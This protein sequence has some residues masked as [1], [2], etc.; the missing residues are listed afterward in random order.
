MILSNVAW[1]YPNVKVHTLAPPTMF[2]P[3]VQRVNGIRTHIEFNMRQREPITIECSFITTP[4]HA[5]RRRIFIDKIKTDLVYQRIENGIGHFANLVNGSLFE[6]CKNSYDS[7]LDKINKLGLSPESF[8][9][10]ITIE[11]FFERND[12]IINVI[13]NG[14]AVEFDEN[15]KLKNRY[16]TIEHFRGNHI[17]TDEIS[18]GAARLEGTIEWHP[19]NEGTMVQIR[20]PKKNIPPEFH[21]SE[22]EYISIENTDEKRRWEEET[23]R[24]AKDNKAIRKRLRKTGKPP[25]KPLV[26]VPARANRTAFYYISMLIGQDLHGLAS[27]HLKDPIPGARAKAMINEIKRHVKSAELAISKTH[28]DVLLAGF[29]LDELLYNESENAYH[30]PIYRDGVKKFEYKFYK[31]EK[32]ENPDDWV[33]PLGDG[34]NVYVSSKYMLDKLIDDIQGPS[35]KID[36]LNLEKNILSAF[37]SLD[38]SRTSLPHKMKHVLAVI[39][40]FNRLINKDFNYFYDSLL[41]RKDRNR[42]NSKKEEKKYKTN[43]ETLYNLYFKL[44]QEVKNDLLLA[45]ILHDIGFTDKDTDDPGHPSKGAELARSILTNTN[46]SEGS[47]ARICEI[48]AYHDYAGNVVRA[49]KVPRVL[50]GLQDELLKLVVIANCMDMAGYG[51]GKTEHVQNNLVPDSLEKALECSDPI[52]LKQL[53][54]QK[55]YFEHRLRKLARPRYGEELSDENFEEL[56]RKIDSATPES[57]RELFINSWNSH[58]EVRTPSFFFNIAHDNG[59]FKPLPLVKILKFITQAAE[60][61][62]NE[63]PK[64][65]MFIVDT[66]I[67]PQD[68]PSGQ[69]KGLFNSLRSNIDKLPVVIKGNKLIFKLKE[70][71]EQTH[72]AEAEDKNGTVPKTASEETWQQV[73]WRKDIA[74]KLMEL[75]HPSLPVLR[76]RGDIYEIKIVKGTRLENWAAKQCA[77]H[78]NKDYDDQYIKQIIKWAI[79]LADAVLILHKVGIE[80]GDISVENVIIDER[81][82]QPVLIDFSDESGPDVDYIRRLIAEPVILRAIPRNKTITGIEMIN[83]I[84]ERFDDILYTIVFEDPTSIEN[85]K[86]NLVAYHILRWGDVQFETGL[87]ITSEA[88]PKPTSEEGAIAPDPTPKTEQAHAINFAREAMKEPKPAFIALG[89]SW[90]EGYEKGRYLQYN[91]LNPL[92]SSLTQLCE[93]KGIPFVCGDDAY[94][95][96]EVQRLKAANSD[97]RGIV[98]AGEGTV[99]SLGLENDENVFLAGVNNEKLTIDSYMPIME[100]LTLLLRL[101]DAK[102]I[103][104]EAL[105]E[106]HKR[107]GIRFDPNKKRC[108]YFT[109]E[110][111]IPEDYEKLRDIYKVQIFA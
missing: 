44:S 58:I 57:E 6:L 71:L 18:K 106:A 81:T 49:K 98:L 36:P 32:P 41:E 75:Q 14:E 50:R 2:N 94:V 19:L 39:Q 47:I 3:L 59:S 79:Q 42:F 66:D 73:Y 78:S 101:M 7:F 77:E 51:S 46:L 68:I 17:A 107:L 21:I 27:E 13:D 34:T 20:I 33:I 109:P 91:A 83:A 60:H 23:V 82:N 11:A 63:N 86:L 74:D 54:E 48:I 104:E 25:K 67:D 45:I 62:L 90:I 15:G 37:P 102:V 93:K 24:A 35:Q 4:P 52:R 76:R 96:S 29:E 97:A 72:P 70:L 12:I 111:I 8:V 56:K 10:K 43:L 40:C 30:L 88:T 5:A 89:T 9:G 105:K 103:D 64:D 108:I 85:F 53:D 38:Y 55:G 16:G 1:A 31:A 84:K 87:S 110:P 69:R 99:N 65:D 92:I 28:L 26:G 95:A 22:N 80:H 61:Y 100:M